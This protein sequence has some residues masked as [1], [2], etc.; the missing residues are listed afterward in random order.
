M[1]KIMSNG[2]AVV[3]RF[4]SMFPGAMARMQM[5][6]KRRGG[7]L[8]HVEMEFIQRNRTILGE[9]FVAEVNAEIHQM[10]AENQDAEVVALKAQKRRKQAE[11]RQERGLVEPWKASEHGPLREVILTAHKDHFRAEPDA[12]D[13]EVLITYGIGPEGETRINRLSKVKI[14]AFEERGRA[15]FEA[16]FP[17]ALRHLRFDL[18]EETPHFHALLLQRTTK[19]SARRGTQHLIQP[20]THPLLKNYEKAQDEA[21]RFF[22]PIGLMRGQTHAENQRRAKADRQTILA[23]PTHTSPREYREAWQRALHQRES[24]IKS[25]WKAASLKKVLVD[26]ALQQARQDARATGA[27]HREAETRITEAGTKT[28]S[29]EALATALTMGMAAIEARQ[30]DYQEKTV[31][32]KE[33][34]RYG[35]NAPKGRAARK[36]LADRIRPAYK[37]LVTFARGLFRNRRRETELEREAAELA[38]QA[39][40]LAR[41][42]EMAGKENLPHL[43]AITKGEPSVKYDEASFPGAW[44]LRPGADLHAIQERMDDMTNASLRNCYRATSDAVRLCDAEADAALRAGFDRGAQILE[45]GAA[46]RGLD[47]ETGTHDPNGAADPKRAELHTD[48]DP[49]P[50]RIRVLNRQR[51]RSWG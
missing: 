19:T 40:V 27:K 6:A 15:F 45:F 31:K 17:D 49:K 26:Q 50:I 14:E 7:P 47:L 16:F 43:D 11:A 37:H 42:R 38:R 13:D 20:S 36:R 28:A 2:H 5:H 29:A 18:D 10:M 34:L 35:P 3:L 12:S 39:G 9:N 21:G 4:A 41:E 33:G 23:A 24:K 44:A 25:E 32:K 22:A 46:Q 30:L 51:Q 8:D 48:I 1:G